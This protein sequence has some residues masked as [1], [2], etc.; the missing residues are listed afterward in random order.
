MDVQSWYWEM[1]F[2]CGV[3]NEEDIWAKLTAIGE[4]PSDKDDQYVQAKITDLLNEAK[5]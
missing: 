4:L 1:S 5:A 2:S 3:G